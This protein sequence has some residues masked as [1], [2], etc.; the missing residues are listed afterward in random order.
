MGAGVALGALLIASGI[1]SL[2]TGW[3]P[4]WVRR[5][6]TRP[7]LFGVG[8]L[9][10]GTPEVVQG[11][12]YFQSA[13]A[14]SWEVRFLGGNLLTFAGLALLVAGH[15]LPPKAAGHRDGH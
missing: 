1:A 8:A 12:L 15:M 11:L 6:V 5:R 13:F 3:V 14:L 2:R 9:L 7:R 10:V 4:P